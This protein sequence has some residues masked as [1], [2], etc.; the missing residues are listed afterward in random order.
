VLALEL[1]SVVEPLPELSAGGGLP[2]LSVG[3]ELSCLKR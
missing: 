1:L 2:E 3:C